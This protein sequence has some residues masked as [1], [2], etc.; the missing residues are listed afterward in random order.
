MTHELLTSTRDAARLYFG[1][2]MHARSRPRVHRFRYRVFAMLI[3]IDRLDAA[4]RLSPLF[5]IGRFNLFSFHERDHGPRD[6]SPLRAHVEDLLQRAGLEP[7]GGRIELLCYPRVLGYVFN[8]LSVYYCSAADGTM[9]AL[10]YQVHNT[11]GDAHTYVAPLQAAERDGRVVRQSRTK[12]MHVSPFVGMS[13]HYDFALD[14]PG[15]HLCVHIREQDDDGPFLLATFD[16][17]RRSLSTSSLVK[18]FFAYPL[19]TLKVMAAIHFEAL[20]L[21]GKGVPFHPRPKDTP[22]KWSAD[23]PPVASEKRRYTSRVADVA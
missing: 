4:D 5:S 6:G 2:V 9:R 18:A 13:A 8:P 11:F 15:E 1:H 12:R 20:R 21:W 22:A 7:D 10:V 3:D 23:G 17:D 19:M 16:G 14:V